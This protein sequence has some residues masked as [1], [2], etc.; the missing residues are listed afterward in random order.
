M[1]YNTDN[2]KT[3]DE[4]KACIQQYDWNCSIP[5]VW[6]PSSLKTGNNIRCINSII[7]KM[8]SFSDAAKKREYV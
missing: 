3:K 5:T 4:W 7:S 6:L 1:L 2:D 8:F